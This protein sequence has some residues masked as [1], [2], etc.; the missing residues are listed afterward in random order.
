MAICWPTCLVRTMIC[1]WV[2]SFS[3]ALKRSVTRCCRAACR[4]T[5]NADV[6][7][8]QLSASDRPY[9]ALLLKAAPCSTVSVPLQPAEAVAHATIRSYQATGALNP[10]STT[11]PSKSRCDGTEKLPG[12]AAEAGSSKVQDGLSHAASASGAKGCST[13]ADCSFEVFAAGAAE[14]PSC[15]HCSQEWRHA[16]DAIM[17]PASADTSQD[18]PVVVAVCGSKGVGK[19]TFARLLTNAMLNTCH[20]VAYLDTDCG[21]PEFTPPGQVSV[22]LVH[23]PVFGPPHLHMRQPAAAHFQA[24]FSHFCAHHWLGLKCLIA[25][26]E[27]LLLNIFFISG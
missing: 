15:L 20:Q 25:L 11:A 18:A 27:A 17:Q 24:S 6:G 4:F 26:F 22:T 1:L 7:P 14:A 9:G 13:A 8:V 12:S 23:Q 21:Q 2:L 5:V 19:S 16:I 10:S 3:V